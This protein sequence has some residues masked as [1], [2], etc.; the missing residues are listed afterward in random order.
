MTF[1]L[2]N[3]V[4]REFIKPAEVGG[5]GR[6]GGSGSVQPQVDIEA[7]N[8]RIQA[9]DKEA[10]KELDELGIS[11][12]L[13]Q[14]SSGG[15]TVEY[16][17]GDKNY[18]VRYYAPP[19]S[20]P[21]I[22]QKEE[23][24]S[25]DS[26]ISKYLQRYDTLYDSTNAAFKG[27]NPVN[28]TEEP[29][30]ADTSTPVPDEAEDVSQTSPD[31]T[32]E[33]T[34][35]EEKDY[36]FDYSAAGVDETVAAEELYNEDNVEKS[37]IRNAMEVLGVGSPV[38]TDVDSGAWDDLFAELEK[39]KPQL[40]EYLK[41]Q[42]EANGYIYDEETADKLLNK[43]ITEGV[44]ALITD[45]RMEYAEENGRG[46][47]A[48]LAGAR[49][50]ENRLKTVEDIVNY[51]KDQIDLSP[52]TPEDNNTFASLINAFKETFAKSWYTS[53]FERSPE[54]ESEDPIFA[55]EK[56]ADDDYNSYIDG[57]HYLLE[58]ADYFLSDEEKEMKEVL[59]IVNGT[60]SSYPAVYSKEEAIGYIDTYSEHLN[61]E[62][63]HQ[64]RLM[65]ESEFDITM[66]FLITSFKVKSIP[67]PDENLGIIFIQDV[68]QAFDKYVRE[69][70]EKAYTNY[71]ENSN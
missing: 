67:E 4:A 3:F 51:I 39:M 14:D 43:F 65:P 24:S 50:P 41:Q 40:K 18:T 62:L 64:Y 11:Y 12:T 38:N 13:T 2:N 61:K 19:S 34:P 10:L 52:E 23:Y 17:Y 68:L 37:D 63:G 44:D 42:L 30:A 60:A 49:E 48:L 46:F 6:V 16:K 35:T 29:E 45:I 31:T 55:M 8:D 71:L 57:D 20:T 7:I 59:E 33:T 32:E 21:S 5:G 28:E 15:Y 26:L 69:E 27:E 36:E 66:D 54:A 47:T 25:Q 53:L 58:T 9:G 70:M 56:L 1:R 22:A